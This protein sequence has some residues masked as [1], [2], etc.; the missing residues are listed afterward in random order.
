MTKETGNM[1][2]ETET[3]EEIK[4]EEEELEEG[5]YEEIEYEE[6][7]L[8]EL[9]EPETVVRI[10]TWLFPA[11]I[12]YFECVLH[13]SIG[14]KASG[15]DILI[16][17]LF[18]CGYGLLLQLIRSFV[19]RTV[20]YRVTTGAL[21]FVSAVP[22]IAAYF[23]FLQFQVLLDLN[24]IFFAGADATENY[25]GEIT[26]MVTSPGGLLRLVM[27]LL[28]AILYAAGCLV[29][30]RRLVLFEASYS[31]K[32]RIGFGIRAAACMLVPTVLIWSTPFM[33]E[34]YADRYQ[35]AEVVKQYGLIT[36]LRRD[37]VRGI[38]GENRKS[39]F[40]LVQQTEPVPETA[41]PVSEPEPEA[42]Y[43]TDPPVSAET[44]TEESAEVN[45]VTEEE[46]VEKVYD[47]NMLDIDF[48]MLAEKTGGAMS[49]IDKYVASLRP[50]RQNRYTGL[51]E[52]KNLI[53]ICAESFSGHMIDEKLTPTLY[54]MQQ[55][56][57]YFKDFHQPF[58]ASTAGGEC[59][60]LFGIQPMAGAQSMELAVGHH[61][62]MTL[63]SFF[64]R[65]GYY[66]RTFHNGDNTY[67]NRDRTH[68]A[69]GYSEKYMAFGSGLE[70][71]I[72]WDTWDRKDKELIEVTLPLYME[73]EHFN[74]YYMTYSGHLPYY[75]ENNPSV[76]RH[77]KRTEKLKYNDMLKGYIAAN[78]E[79]ED[80]VTY[81][82]E[83]LEENGRLEDTVIVVVPDHYPYGLDGKEANDRENLE[84]LYGH[85]VTNDLERDESCFIIW[86]PMLTEMDPIVVEEPTTSIDVLP[87][88][89][90]L[91]GLPF[92]SRLFPGVDALSDAP[93]IAFNITYDWKTADGT[94]V[95]A[96]GVFTPAE[97]VDPATLPDDY[98]QQMRT[99][100]NNKI[101]YSR[102]LTYND[103][104]YHLFGDMTEEG[105]PWIKNN[106]YP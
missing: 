67:Y 95:N 104:F 23:I 58:S 96:T 60:L 20:P 80:A 35:Y 48:E 70:K 103:Y 4:N 105:A 33:R 8:T 102:S 5:E 83:E 63:G 66:G 89:L 50:S 64:T 37:I 10:S 49:N 30:D 38:T 24:T 72:E 87:T 16:T 90:N 99:T 32:H 97:G 57:I 46:P 101:E 79:L 51:F 98:V 18:S 84:T 19:P 73:E 21:L 17:L 3:K 29:A 81:L 27:F 6:V 88:L 11:V 106:P 94:Y 59:Q 2:N 1:M 69:L 75:K 34:S 28:P 13:L 42:V 25:G 76:E 44:E 7:E 92:D 82:K 12:F 93:H 45:A 41:A 54:Q 47:Y 56:G 86:T 68:N 100:V 62:Y 14:A 40:E 71:M 53:F 9:F 36:G 15:L 52:G 39:T 74:V 85:Q 22:Y 31:K 91:F 65:E 78:L 26:R 77:Y 61:N 43:E 55:E